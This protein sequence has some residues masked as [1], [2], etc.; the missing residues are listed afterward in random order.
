MNL[1]FCLSDLLL[2]RGDALYF[3]LNAS[4]KNKIKGVCVCNRSNMGLHPWIDWS[5]VQSRKNPVITFTGSVHSE[6]TV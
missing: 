5:E 4:E 1:D 3:L 6:V 2:F